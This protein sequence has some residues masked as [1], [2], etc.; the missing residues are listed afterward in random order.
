M[1]R[2]F[3]VSQ[4]LFHTRGDYVLRDVQLGCWR[5]DDGAYQPL[6]AASFLWRKVPYLFAIQK[7]NCGVENCFAADVNFRYAQTGQ[8]SK[9]LMREA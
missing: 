9:N 5:A 7:G 8:F 4:E 2:I 3:S 1:T 6:S